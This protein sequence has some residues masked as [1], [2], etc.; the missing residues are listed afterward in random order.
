W[1]KIRH[2][3][4]VQGCFRASHRERTTGDISTVW[5][6]L[7]QRYMRRVCRNTSWGFR[8]ERGVHIILATQLHWQDG[9]NDLEDLSLISSN[10][11]GVGH[12]REDRGSKEIP[13]TSTSILKGRSWVWPDEVHTDTII[14]VRFKART[15]DTVALVRYVM[16]G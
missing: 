12:R 14:P 15:T 9:R 5:R 6:N 1:D 16:A 3:T 10:G 11:R 8:G 4:S 13:M 2:Y 7:Q